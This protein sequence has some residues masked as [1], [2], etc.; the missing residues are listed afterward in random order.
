MDNANEIAHMHMS[1]YSAMTSDTT[2]NDSI[3]AGHYDQAGVEAGYDSTV[4]GTRGLASK[5][6]E[7]SLRGM[8]ARSL[9]VGT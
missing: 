4:T 6:L 7:W 1:K 5:V 8:E 3:Q 9:V 2:T